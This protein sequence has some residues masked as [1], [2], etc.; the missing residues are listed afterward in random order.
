[1]YRDYNEIM[2]ELATESMIAEAIARKIDTLK[3]ELKD[4]MTERDI[5]TLDGEEH[6]AAYKLVRSSHVD[7]SA[8]KRELPEVA[9][10]YTE[11]RLTWRFTFA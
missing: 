6:R 5:E 2:K 9:D 1:M 10:R 11:S 4:Y 7:V 3:Q 8:L